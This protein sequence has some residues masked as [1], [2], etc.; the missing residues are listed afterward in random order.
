MAVALQIC[1]II[2]LCV[3]L[4]LKAAGILKTHWPVGYRFM[5]LSIGP[6]VVLAAILAVIWRRLT[7]GIFNE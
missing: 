3:M 7:K 2:L 1:G 6:A 5:V 4:R